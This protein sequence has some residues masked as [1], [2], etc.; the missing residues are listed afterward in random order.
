MCFGGAAQHARAAISLLSNPGIDEEANVFTVDPFDADVI[1][2]RTVSERNI[3]ADRNLRQT[4]QV[5]SPFIVQEINFSLGVETG[6]INGGLELR[7]YLIDDVGA[8]SWTP[9]GAHFHEISITDTLPTSSE[10]FGLQLSGT[11]VFELVQRNTGTQGYGIEFSNADGSTNLGPL[12]FPNF[13]PA[14]A[15]P[16]FDPNF[17]S[18]YA[19]GRYYTEGGGASNLHRDLG[20]SLSGIGSG[21]APGDTNGDEIIDIENDLAAILA[22]YLNN[23]TGRENG[24]LTGDGIVDRNDFRQWK[25]NFPGAN[26]PSLASL[27]AGVPEPNSLVQLGVGLLA[28]CAGRRR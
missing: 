3:A 23:V 27:L 22:N 21:G 14:E 9:T 13:I 17:E 10:T 4:F 2:G 25:D 11:D 18:F 1:M 16:D 19:G 7:F 28:G 12:S 26:P 5:D 6:G 8:S 24:E 20:L 15:D